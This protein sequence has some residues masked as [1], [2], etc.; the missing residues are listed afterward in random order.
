[1]EL[2]FGDIAISRLYL[3][4]VNHNSPLPGRI[5][6]LHHPITG[7][8]MPKFLPASPG[9]HKPRFQWH[10]EDNFEAENQIQ[11]CMKVYCPNILVLRNNLYTY[12]FGDHDLTT[13]SQNLSRYHSPIPGVFPHYRVLIPGIKYESIPDDGCII[14]CYVDGLVE[15]HEAVDY[16]PQEGIPQDPLI[17]PINLSHVHPA[18][19]LAETAKLAQSFSIDQDNLGDAS[20][21]DASN[22]A[23]PV[24]NPGAEQAA[25]PPLPTEPV[26]NSGPTGSPNIDNTTM[27]SPP[28]AAHARPAYTPASASPTKDDVA[29]AERRAAATKSP[30]TQP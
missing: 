7:V 3:N 15:Y 16:C 2:S 9:V 5:A 23:G 14:Q 21:N 26:D 30:T 1:M 27:Q 22:S 19:A 24:D 17:V 4:L 8:P 13:L 25:F 11:E 28:L 6:P 20:N 10:D 12:S 18:S 29:T